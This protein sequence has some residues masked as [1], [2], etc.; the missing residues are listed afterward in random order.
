M[1]TRH[2]ENLR[3]KITPYHSTNDDGILALKF[4][5]EICSEFVDFLAM[6]IDINKLK[7]KKLVKNLRRSEMNK[8][9]A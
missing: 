8:K 4:K 1:K 5:L 9:N 6:I 3:N 7:I 2:T